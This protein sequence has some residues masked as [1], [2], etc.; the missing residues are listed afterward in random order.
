MLCSGYCVRLPTTAPGFDSR[1]GCECVECKETEW[2]GNAWSNF[3]FALI[4]CITVRVGAAMPAWGIAITWQQLFRLRK[5]RTAMLECGSLRKF[6]TTSSS[7]GQLYIWSQ[8]SGLLLINKWYLLRHS[9]LFLI[10]QLMYCFITRCSN[11]IIT[12]SCF[13][14]SP[15]QDSFS[16]RV[17]VKFA[18]V[19]NFKESASF[20]LCFNSVFTH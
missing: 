20:W 9:T 11:S 16:Y 12:A 14:F 17:S 6:W 7:S 10:Q 15:Y 5:R 3:F 1:L 2:E 19:R 8:Q 13:Y 18:A 4:P